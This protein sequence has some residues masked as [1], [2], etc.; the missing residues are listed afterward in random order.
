MLLYDVPNLRLDSVRVDVYSTFPGEAGVPRQL[1]ILTT[2]ALRGEAEDVAWEAMTPAE[3]LG[4]FETR[5]QRTPA[6]HGLPIDLAPVVGD[7][8]PSPLQLAEATP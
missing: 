4:R 6:G 1:P 3:V 5:Y 8:P 2:T 7:P